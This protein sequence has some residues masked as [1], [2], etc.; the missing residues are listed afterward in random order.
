MLIIA[1]S[2]GGTGQSQARTGKAFSSVATDLPIAV[3][4][5]FRKIP[6]NEQNSVN[7]ADNCLKDR[8]Y[9][10]R[11]ILRDAQEADVI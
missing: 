6:F 5:K 8:R 2:T 11:D 3:C 7:G 4:R 10:K 1:V 9:Y